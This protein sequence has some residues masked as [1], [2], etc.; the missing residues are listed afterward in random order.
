MDLKELRYFRAIVH[1]GTM[2][3]AAAH[4]RIAQPALTRQVQKLEHDL[5]V[6]L[7][8]R[9]TRGVTPT[10]AGLSLMKRTTHLENEL[11]DIRREVSGFAERVTG[12]LHFAM[13][14][15][16]TTLMVPDLIVDFKQAYPDVSLHV[17]ENVSRSI[18]DGLLSEQLDLAVVDSPS[19]D[20][21]D[22][23]IIPLWIER[24]RLVGPASAAKSLLF[25]KPAA[26]I[27][28]I[29]ALPMIMPTQHH[30]LR[31]LAEAAFAREKMQFH[32]A[33]EIDGAS[34]ICE[35][36]RRG[37]GY[38]LMPQAGFHALEQEGGL[39]AMDVKPEIRRVVSIVTRTVLLQDTKTAALIAKIRDMAPAV[40]AM[41]I[42]GP[43][44]L[45]Q[46]GDDGGAT[47]FPTLALAGAA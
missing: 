4:L 26:T 11:D 40:A 33:L 2:C 24:L 35:T 6:Q 22:L 42:L 15:P 9:T 20:H 5:G 16:L 25:R 3:K 41:P 43:A 7:L 30:A 47:R 8:R 13:Q 18:T 21:A 36:V 44:T 12:S 45:Y 37:L 1:C 19:H 31:R 17:I 34:T 14:Y 32:P 23:T 10:P 29:A 28:D 38:T 39:V 46:S 27:K